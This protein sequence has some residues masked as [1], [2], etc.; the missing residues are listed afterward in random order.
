MKSLLIM[1]A[2][3]LIFF[4]A[5]TNVFASTDGIYGLNKKLTTSWV[6]LTKTAKSQVSSTTNCYIRDSEE[7][8]PHFSSIAANSSFFTGLDR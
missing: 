3:T 6:S 5:S 8:Y 2:I 7:I 1:V 4:T